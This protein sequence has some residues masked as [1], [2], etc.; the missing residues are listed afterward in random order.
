LSKEAAKDLFAILNAQIT[1]VSIDTYGTYLSTVDV[2]DDKDRP[3]VATALACGIPIWS[4]DADLRNDTAVT[5]YT[6]S[7]LIER[8]L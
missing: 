1:I 8:L 4:D 5:V 7:D 3:Y 2:S 6:T